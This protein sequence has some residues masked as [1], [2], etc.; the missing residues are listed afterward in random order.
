MNRGSFTIGGNLASVQNTSSDNK[1]K[2][3]IIYHFTALIAAAAR[4]HAQLSQGPQTSL[5]DPDDS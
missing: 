3:L 2:V 5:G 4:I 1:R